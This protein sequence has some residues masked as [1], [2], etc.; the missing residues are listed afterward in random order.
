MDDDLP[1]MQ[2]LQEQRFREAQLADY[3]EAGRTAA[4]GGIRSGGG[5]SIVFDALFWVATKVLLFVVLPGLAAYVLLVQQ[6]PHVSVSRAVLLTLFPD[7]LVTTPDGQSVADGPSVATS[8]WITILV[9]AILLWGLTTWGRARL[10]PDLRAARVPGRPRPDRAP[11]SRRGPVPRLGWQRAA[12]SRS[13]VR[14]PERDGSTLLGMVAVDA[15][16]D[17]CRNTVP[18]IDSTSSRA[19]RGAVSGFSPPPERANP[20]GWHGGEDRYFGGGRATEDGHDER[21]QRDGPVGQHRPVPVVE[22]DPMPVPARGM[23]KHRIDA[24]QRA[25]GAD[26]EAVPQRPLGHLVGHVALVKARGETHD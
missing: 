21:A 2:A 16:R 6:L 3:H 19:S 15:R 17:M 14:R 1:G 22:L 26:P 5:D 13:V 20:I 24:E 18:E 11:H 25:G 9:T 23:P 12:D 7:D 8:Y 10:G 4:A